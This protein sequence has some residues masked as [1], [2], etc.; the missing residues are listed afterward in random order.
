MLHQFL[1]G[2]GSLSL[3]ATQTGCKRYRLNVPALV[4]SVAV[5]TVVITVYMLVVPRWLGFESMDLGITMG[6]LVDPTDSPLAY[7]VRVAWHVGNSV[8]YVTLFIYLLYLL[9]INSTALLGVALGIFLWMMGPMLLI[10]W[11]LDFL[12][13]IA[14]GEV[15]HPGIFMLDLGFGWRPAA[16]DLVVH[17][18]HGILAA[19]IYQHRVSRRR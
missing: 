9:Q 1:D 7:A 14:S 18:L 15:K 6:R 10:P 5:S 3:S 13:R 4:F 16:V 8:L 11:S 12:P 19:T 17:L 2:S